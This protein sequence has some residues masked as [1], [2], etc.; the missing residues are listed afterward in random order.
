MV[1]RV[2]CPFVDA[3]A[4]ANLHGYGCAGDNP[5]TDGYDQSHGHVI[6]N[7]QSCV[8][9]CLKVSISEGDC[10]PVYAPTRDGA[11]LMLNSCLYFCRAATLLRDNPIDERAICQQHV[12]AQPGHHRLEQYPTRHAPTL[13]RR[14]R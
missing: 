7:I 4:L 10:A 6:E 9:R 11:N 8:L 13:W 1:D 14:R 5:P 2:V 3:A 12:V